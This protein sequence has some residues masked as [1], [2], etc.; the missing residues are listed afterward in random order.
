MY[1]IAQ[2]CAAVDKKAHW[3]ASVYCISQ[4][5]QVICRISYIH[6]V[7]F[8]SLRYAVWSRLL[9][10]CIHCEF[11]VFVSLRSIVAVFITLSVQVKQQVEV[12]PESR[13]MSEESARRASSAGAAY[14][15]RADAGGD[16]ACRASPRPGE[17]GYWQMRAAMAGINVRSRGGEVGGEARQQTIQVRDM[18]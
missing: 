11:I 17:R 12:L 18:L 6:S 3:Y 8:L 7:F 14:A 10:R 9:L 15:G 5:C 13:A 4:C 1:C 2:W 16:V